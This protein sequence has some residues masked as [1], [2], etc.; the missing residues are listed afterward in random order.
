MIIRQFYL[1]FCADIVVNMSAGCLAVFQSFPLC[2]VR[3]IA[4][5]VIYGM[6][7]LSADIS[8]TC[9]KVAI[10]FCIV[11][12]CKVDIM[13]IQCGSF[14]YFTRMFLILN[15]STTIFT[16]VLRIAINTTSRIYSNSLIIVFRCCQITQNNSIHKVCCPHKLI[17]IVILLLDQAIQLSAI[18]AKI[19]TIIGIIYIGS[20]IV[21]FLECISRIIRII[22]VL[23][24]GDKSVIRCQ[25][26]RHLT[27]KNIDSRNRR[28]GCTQCI[29]TVFVHNRKGHTAK[30]IIHI[31][32]CVYFVVFQYTGQCMSFYIIRKNRVADAHVRNAIR[33]SH[34]YVNTRVV[35]CIFLETAVKI[36][37]KSALFHGLT[38]IE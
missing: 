30:G 10:S 15:D 6:Q 34:G 13:M 21:G 3:I 12:F 37:Q 22:G 19:D 24:T 16:S 32:L 1:A 14:I 28:V 4:V 9:L 5:I 27:I 25:R 20:I 23:L 17:V 38:V 11:C 36:F 7:T 29:F 18:I 33:I 35:F 26:N 2:F 31:T 8:L